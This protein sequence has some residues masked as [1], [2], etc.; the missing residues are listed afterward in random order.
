MKRQQEKISTYNAQFRGRYFKY[1]SFGDLH[2]C[3]NAV[4]FCANQCKNIMLK[5]DEMYI[6]Q[7]TNGRL[8]LTNYQSSFYCCNEIESVI[9]NGFITSEEY[10]AL[11]EKMFDEFRR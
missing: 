10:D 8:N 6:S 3:K 2:I 9:E 7:E 11:A 4:A 1:T 5:F